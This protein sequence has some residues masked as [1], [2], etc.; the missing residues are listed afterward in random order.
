M[1]PSGDKIFEMMAD[2]NQKSNQ[3]NQLEEISTVHRDRVLSILLNTCQRNLKE[4]VDL[5]PKIIELLSPEPETDIWINELYPVGAV[6][7]DLKRI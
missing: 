4:M 2:I 1:K 6:T 7:G 5:M 3:N